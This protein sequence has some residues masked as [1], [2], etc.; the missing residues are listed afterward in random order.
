MST[1]WLG[2]VCSNV[3]LAW[4]VAICL[5][6][7]IVL[8]GIN[9]QCHWVVLHPLWNVPVMTKCYDFF[10]LVYVPF[11]RILLIAFCILTTVNYSLKT[12]MITICRNS[13]ILPKPDSSTTNKQRLPVKS[14]WLAL[15]PT[16]RNNHCFTKSQ[17]MCQSRHCLDALY[18][19][20]K[21]II[22]CYY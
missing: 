6:A 16:L 1:R 7:I 13:T 19:S 17:L 22:Y 3:H 5:S 4:T 11:H 10:F 8:R 18:L 2:G 12:T 15:C 20:W 14:S 9:L 21:M